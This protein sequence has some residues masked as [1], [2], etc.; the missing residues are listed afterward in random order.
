[1]QQIQRGKTIQG[2]LVEDP[3]QIQTQNGPMVVMTVA[4]QNQ[5]FDRE[6]Q[7]YVD[8]DPTYYDVGISREKLGQNVL[9]SV[10]KGDRVSVTGNYAVE[11]YVS[12]KGEPGL[13]H[14]IWAEDV[15]ASMQF[16]QVQVAP[17]PNRTVARDGAERG[18]Q[19]EAAQEATKGG[20]I[21]PGWPLENPPA[22]LSPQE[23]AGVEAAQQAQQGPELAGPSR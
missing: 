23:Q 12:K 9:A 2:N 4:E 15:G 16:D 10:H 21:V 7:Q 14:R 20:R 17:R 22:G 18:Q 6:S 3:K 13:N 8:M 19:A 5:R 1:M 11:P